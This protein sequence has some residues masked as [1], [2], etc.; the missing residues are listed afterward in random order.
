MYPRAGSI[1]LQWSDS[2]N[3][4]TQRTNFKFIPVIEPIEKMEWKSSP[5]DSNGM[6]QSSL[7]LRWP[8]KLI[9]SCTYLHNL[10][11]PNDT[12]VKTFEIRNHNITVIKRTVG[13]VYFNAG[14]FL[15]DGEK[16]VNRMKR[17]TRAQLDISQNTQ[18]NVGRKAEPFFWQS[19]V[20]T[21][22]WVSR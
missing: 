9:V 5:V 10:P 2:Y 3:F 12:I 4:S 21:P 16:E 7:I 22:L 20:N 15:E 6:A 18:S 19:W 11:N 14:Y 8:A 13:I 17:Q 1:K